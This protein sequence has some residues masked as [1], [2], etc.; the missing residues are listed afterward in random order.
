MSQLHEPDSDTSE[1]IAFHE[2]Q[3]PKSKRQDQSSGLLRLPAEL[4]NRIYEHVLVEEDPIPIEPGLKL[5]QLLSTCAQIRE[6]ATLL[7]FSENDFQ[8]VITDCDST[9][10][11]CFEDWSYH[12]Q[13]K[14]SEPEDHFHP[15]RSMEIRGAIKWSALEDWVKAVWSSSVSRQEC[16]ADG[17]KAMAII[18][19]AHDIAEQH[20]ERSWEECQKALD[21]L[22]TPALK[23]PPLVR[24][25][26][27]IYRETMLYWTG[28]NTFVVDVVDYDS[29]LLLNY[30][31]FHCRC[32]YKN[33]FEKET[34]PRISC[35]GSIH[36]TNLQGW[37]KAIWSWGLGALQRSPSDDQEEVIIASAL[38]IAEQH[39]GRLWEDCQQ[40]LDTL[41][42]TIEGL[43]N[44]QIL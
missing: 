39:R 5:P 10:L 42:N 9:S 7:W 14:F 31:K 21:I 27:Q 16:S 15:A 6:E 30:V 36:W 25:C 19:G 24:A 26:Y 22:V 8:T 3:K 33:Q 18:V 11:Q 23:V 38:E 41:R 13:N 12:F 17:D 1:A 4:R 32:R 43:S 20:L 40:A 29:T 28:Q 35:A 34:G 44:V 37:A 2:E